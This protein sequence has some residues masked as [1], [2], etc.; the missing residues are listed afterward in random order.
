M[1]RRLCRL[2]T[3][4]AGTAGIEFAI[5]LPIML[6][7]SLVALETTLAIMAS[8]SLTN[9]A[10]S[11][12][13]IVA[14]QNSAG[15]SVSNVCAAGQMSMS[16]LSGTPLSVAIASVTNNGG[17]APT[18]NW[19]DTSCGSAGGISNAASLA[20]PLIPDSGDSVIVVQATYGYTPPIKYLFTSMIN[21]TQTSFQ[22]PRNG[23]SV[24]AP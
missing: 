24:P 19:Q 9:A 15:W 17:S 7:L 21:M 10:D 2:G 20:A 11:V 18:V 22:R 8:M 12:A 16:P 5:V 3:D 23:S 4:R 13:D 6:L 14:Q 1:R